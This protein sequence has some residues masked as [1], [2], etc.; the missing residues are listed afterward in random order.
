MPAGVDHRLDR[1][2]HSGLESRPRVGHSV[3]GHVRVLVHRATDAVTHVLTH[4]AE[5]LRLGNRLNGCPDVEEPLAGEA[6]CDARF[7]RRR[8]RVEQKTRLL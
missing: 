4:H 8:G 3:V 6:L 1:Q 2:D 5:P 7:Q